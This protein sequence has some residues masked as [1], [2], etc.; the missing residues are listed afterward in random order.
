MKRLLKWAVIPVV[1]LVFATVCQGQAVTRAGANANLG[2]SLTITGT[3]FDPSGAPAPGVELFVMPQ[4]GFLQGLKAGAGGKFTLSWQP[5]TPAI[6]DILVGRDWEHNFAATASIDDTTTNMDLHLKPG[7]VLS[8]SVQDNNGAA[9]K[10]VTVHLSILDGNW[11]QGFDG[12]LAP[13]PA[14]PLGVQRGGWSTLVGQPLPTVDEQG[15]FTYS[16][17]PQ[18]EAYRLVV[19]APGFGK[20]SVPVSATETERAS[21]IL[22]P[23]KLKPADQ[24][25]EGWVVG[26]DDKPVPGASVRVIGTGMSMDGQPIASVLTDA[27]GHF[28]LK[29]C[30]GAVRITATAPNN[31]KG[32]LRSNSVQAQSGDLDVVL[33]LGAANGAPAAAPRGNNQ[34]QPNHPPVI[35]PLL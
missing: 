18:G 24:R 3:V 8:G 15:A 5:F 16:A 13:P 7:L 1:A 19:T 30:E 17:L 32:Q 35:G 23:I 11:N 28:A 9:V 26:L 6:P 2:P 27:N 33:K 25:L 12:P 14:P 22:P 29:V 10:T 21:L 4:G 20:A 31:I 34:A